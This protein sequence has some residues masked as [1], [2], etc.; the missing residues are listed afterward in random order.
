MDDLKNKY[1]HL[2]EVDKE[3][4]DEIINYLD[5][6]CGYGG[7]VTDEFDKGFS[8]A[9]DMAKDLVYQFSKED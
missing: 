1:P 2:D 5:N 3:I 7:E 4:I 8:Q 9:V 6:F